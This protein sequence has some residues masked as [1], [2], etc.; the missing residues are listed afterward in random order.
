MLERINV[1][2][3]QLLHKTMLNLLIRL[4]LMSV[5]QSSWQTMLN[6]KHQLQKMQD[7]LMIPLSTLRK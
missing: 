1:S 2:Q 5:E 7:T 6:K 4:S 3:K